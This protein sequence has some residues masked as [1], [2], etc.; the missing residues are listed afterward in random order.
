MC[1]MMWKACLYFFVCNCNYVYLYQNK[2][3]YLLAWVQNCNFYVRMN[4]Q[5]KG[6]N[7]S[8]MY[9]IMRIHEYTGSIYG[10]VYCFISKYNCA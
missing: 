1:S 10:S 5:K 9:I 6:K 4:N 7:E 8:F 3:V 2:Y